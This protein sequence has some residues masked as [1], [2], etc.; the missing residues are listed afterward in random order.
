MIH[1]ANLGGT[2][3]LAKSDIETMHPAG[4]PQDLWIADLSLMPRSQVTLLPFY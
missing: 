2:M 1:G 3:P 4:L